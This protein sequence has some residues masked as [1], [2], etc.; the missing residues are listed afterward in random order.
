MEHE[1]NN[2][3]TITRP[4]RFDVRLSRAGSVVR[5]NVP[6]SLI[7]YTKNGF[8]WG[9][10]TPGAFDLA[11]NILNAFAPPGEHVHGNHECRHG[12][13]SARAWKSHKHFVVK[14]LQHI[15]EIGG[16][17]IQAEI[18]AFIA[19]EITREA[20][21]TQNERRQEMHMS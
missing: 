7:H 4:M 1:E 18:V 9:G 15:P 3:Q 2:L 10:M 12:V 21:E 8:D 19:S 14:H 17:I 5:T 6:V 13:A 20:D 16:I 11:L